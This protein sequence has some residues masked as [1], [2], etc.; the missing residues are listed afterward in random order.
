[1]KIAIMGCGNMGSALAKQ[2][3]VSNTIYLYDHHFEKAEKLQKEGYGKAFNELKTALKDVE[4]LILAVKPQSLQK[5]VDE[6][7][8]ESIPPIIFSLLAGT[9]IATLKQH[10][11]KQKIIRMMPNLAVMY[12]EGLIGLVSDNSV[13]EIEKNS[14]LKLCDPLGKVYYISEEKIDAFTALAGSGPAFIFAMIE[15]MIESGIAMGFNARLS[16]ELVHQMINGTLHLLEKSGK[17]P[18]E[19]KWQVTSPEGT[20]IAGLRKLEEESIRGSIINTF[21]ATYER[22]KELSK[23]K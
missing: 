8:K 16:Q 23:Q 6:I 7:K 3:S 17:H 12:G 18:G 2:L 19:L 11:P 9:T 1:M 20:T 15:A 4:I 21:I 14:F 5:A 10:F 13:T 22:A